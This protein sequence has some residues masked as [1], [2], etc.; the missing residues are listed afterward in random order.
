ML[1]FVFLQLLLQVFIKREVNNESQSFG[2]AQMRI[3]PGHQTERN[4]PYYLFAGSASQAA[5]G[6]MCTE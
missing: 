5:S 6:L 3:L 1:E 2:E 4:D